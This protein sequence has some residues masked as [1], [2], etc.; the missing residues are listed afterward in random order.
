[1]FLKFTM[2]GVSHDLAQLICKYSKNVCT[3]K[4]K[5]RKSHNKY[6]FLSSCPKRAEY[7][8]FQRIFA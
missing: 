8:D 6:I 3:A 7:R 4:F 1:M 5:R 2:S